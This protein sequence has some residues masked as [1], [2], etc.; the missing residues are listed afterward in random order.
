[1]RRRVIDARNLNKRVV[2]ENQER[3]GD[4]EMMH[5]HHKK[6]CKPGEEDKREIDSAVAPAACA[7]HGFD[8][9]GW[10]MD[11]PP[12]GSMISGKVG[13]VGRLRA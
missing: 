12:L 1:M 9:A 3:M 4:Q 11:V 7:D 13:D 2:E 5:V 8:P 10:D 6:V